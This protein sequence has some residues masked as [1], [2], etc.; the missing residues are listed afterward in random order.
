MKCL[1]CSSLQ[2]PPH[3]SVHMQH[4]KPLSINYF[5]RSG[6][7][8]RQADRAR[9]AVWEVPEQLWKKLPSLHCRSALK[10]QVHSALSSLLVKQNLQMKEKETPLKISNAHSGLE[11]VHIDTRETDGASTSRSCR[12]SPRCREKRGSKLWAT[13]KE[14]RTWDETRTF[15]RVVTQMKTSRETEEIPTTLWKMFVIKTGRN[16]SCSG[17]NISRC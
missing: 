2:H 15:Q 11:I 5:C 10:L 7:F 1:R 9:P 12:G 8:P 16:I 13:Q 6:R 3:S 17:R 14:T 4:G